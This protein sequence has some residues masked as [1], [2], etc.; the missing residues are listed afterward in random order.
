MA[1]ALGL[2]D[3]NVVATTLLAGG[4]A[5]LCIEGL[6]LRAEAELRASFGPGGAA[7]FGPGGMGGRLRRSIE[8]DPR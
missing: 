4:R 5:A 2:L 1:R 8:A 3:Q 7:M 6:E